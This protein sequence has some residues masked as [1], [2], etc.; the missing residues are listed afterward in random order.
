MLPEAFLAVDVILNLLAN[1]STGLQ[2]WPNVIRAHIRAELPFMATENIL[3]ACVKAGGDRQ[4]LHEVIREFSMQAGRRVKEEGASND[5]MD[6]I[7]KDDRFAAVHRDLEHLMDPKR[8]VGRCPEQVDEFVLECVEPLLIKH[9]DLLRV[10][11]KDEI[12]L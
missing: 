10:E 4:E 12:G 9:Q 6:R 1:I 5:L 7:A 3:M 2:V 11:N 8:F